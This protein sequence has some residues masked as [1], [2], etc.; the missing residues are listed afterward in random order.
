[1][2]EANQYIWRI[3]R[4]KR[5]SEILH[6]VSFD[7][8]GSVA[9]E[10]AVNADNQP[11]VNTHD[12][13]IVKTLPLQRTLHQRPHIVIAGHAMNRQAKRREQFAETL[14]GFEAVVLDQVAGHCHNI[15]GPLR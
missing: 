8:T 9:R 4:I 12:F 2:V 6:L 5:T 11:T 1:M 13:T 14:V 15:G 7:L 10:T 3:S